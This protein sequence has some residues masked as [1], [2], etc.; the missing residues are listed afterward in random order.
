M[1]DDKIA[2]ILALDSYC[3]YVPL[4]ENAGAA[5]YQSFCDD[6]AFNEFSTP[7]VISLKKK[8]LTSQFF[9]DVFSLVPR[10]EYVETLLMEL[11]VN[12]FKLSLDGDVDGSVRMEALL[13]AADRRN[14]LVLKQFPLAEI[15][16]LFDVLYWD[17]INRVCREDDAAT[18]ECLDYLLPLRPE[19]LQDN[20]ALL[21]LEQNRL[22]CNDVD[23]IFDSHQLCGN[24]VLLKLLTGNEGINGLT[25]IWYSVLHMEYWNCVEV[26]W[27]LNSSEPLVGLE[28]DECWQTPFMFHFLVGKFIELGYPQG[29]NSYHVC[30]PRR[31]LKAAVMA[32]DLKVLKYIFEV[33][34]RD[35]PV[36]DKVTVVGSGDEEGWSE[37]YFVMKA[38]EHGR[39]DVM[40][41]LLKHGGKIG[42]SAL[43]AA[44]HGKIEVLEW[45]YE[46]DIYY[47][48]LMVGEND[49]DSIYH[50]ALRQNHV[51]QWLC[52]KE[53]EGIHKKNSDGKTA[54]ELAKEGGDAECIR[55][56]SERLTQLNEARLKENEVLVVQELK[57]F[58]AK[59]KENEEEM[60]DMRAK[61]KKFD[62][63]K[64]EMLELRAKV[65]ENEEEL[66][67]LRAKL[68]EF[69]MEKEEKDSLK[70]IKRGSKRK[71]TFT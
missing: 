37:N 27:K 1:I 68:K 36:D 48:S 17:L 65:K 70:E 32:G 64:E 41:V 26:L 22:E 33:Y 59:L 16:N 9:V 39:I 5:I 71:H 6:R 61:L 66:L 69:D 35:A 43:L 4:G 67:E 19:S 34:N 10:A 8:E 23:D 45:L 58:R 15:E 53:I 31:I 24:L 18:H 44:L 12:G 60:A 11:F 30:D 21:S 52:D 28:F 25:G 29:H 63:N 54:L 40:K 13:L 57:D 3:E 14:L 50:Y 20:I 51:L 55:I 7:T 56:L 42:L 49:E 46:H 47:N 62:E 38:A 2:L